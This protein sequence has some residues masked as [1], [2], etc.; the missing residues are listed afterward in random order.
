MSANENAHALRRLAA[1]DIGTNSFHI[2]I[3]EV[4]PTGRFTVVTREKEVVRLG[5][6]PRDIKTL[7]PEAEQ[8]AYH[9]LEHF[10]KLVDSYGAS[11]RAVA[12]SAVREAANRDA[13]VE[14]VRRR[15]GFEIEVVS[16]FEEARLIYL[17]VLQA[18]PV[19]H[20]QIL[21]FDIGGG[22]T[23]FLVGK[24]GDVLYAN[25]IKIGAV[26]LTSRFFSSGAVRKQ[27]I[28][29]CRTYLAGELH[30]VAR[31]IR[32][33]GFEI[34]VGSSGTILTMA[35]IICAKRGEPYSALEGTVTIG[36][37]E[38]IDAVNTLLEADTLVLRKRIPGL[39]EE[40]ADIIVAGALILEQIFMAF[41]LD[42]M[43]TSRY[44]LREGVILDTIQKRAGVDG[45]L[46]HLANIRMAS[47]IHLAELC[48]YEE[49]HARTVARIALELFD[50]TTSLHRLGPA[51]RELL[52]AA[53]LLHDIGYHIS[54]SQ[55][56]RHS[57]YLIKNSEMLG[58]SNREIDIIAGVARY[59]RKSHPRDSHLEFQSLPARD[60]DIIKRLA[61]LL[62]LADGL[63]RSHKSAVQQLHCNI[64][65]YETEVLLTPN[66]PHDCSLEIWGADRRKELFEDV[67]KRNVIVKAD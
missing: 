53:A 28:E 11:A 59:H 9:T 20:K 58:F 15:T 52:E 13:F 31:E 50:Q 6:A 16:G 7:A 24:A 32:A 42:T 21:L 18:L 56:H 33:D 14:E 57:Y 27:D 64:T 5:E 47:V 67:F 66:P 43:T 41:G 30:P 46:P 10:K 54:H 40:R 2:V 48:R 45:P 36:R 34:A 63:D 25:S 1:I 8:R 35:S 38:L 22:S 29:A 61:S 26:R 49:T 12:T 37:A 39:D 23:E 51:E 65:S 60:Q 19:F 62:R 17:G 3:A 44:A 55:H 4:K